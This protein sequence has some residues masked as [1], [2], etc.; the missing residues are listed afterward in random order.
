MAKHEVI[1]CDMAGQGGCLG[2]VDTYTIW[3]QSD[4]Q[5]VSVDV[6]EEHAAPLVTVMKV[7]SVVDLP[8]KPRARMERTV[9]KTTPATAHLKKRGHSVNPA[10]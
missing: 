1:V 5:A 9:L 10:D 3:R 4:R 7:G 6:C 2:L 8:V